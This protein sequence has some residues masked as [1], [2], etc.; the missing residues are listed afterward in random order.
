MA[1][2]REGWSQL[3]STRGM[4][5][6]I[7]DWMR[8]FTPDANGGDALIV[9]TACHATGSVRTLHGKAKRGVSGGKATAALLTGG[10]SLAAVGLSRK[11]FVTR[12]R[13]A[14]C[15]SEWEM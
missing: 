11:Q 4:Q 3:P 7:V 12:A 13:C 9:C 10:L 5:V 15:N 8:F 2:M 14:Q 1:T 6:G